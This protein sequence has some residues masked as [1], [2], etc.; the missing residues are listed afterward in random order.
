MKI[1]WKDQD[2]KIVI[3]V[4]EAQ[5]AMAH[6]FKT[7]NT[8]AVIRINPERFAIHKNT[9]PREEVI[10]RLTKYYE[11]KTI[12][13]GYCMISPTTPIY[14]TVEIANAKIEIRGSKN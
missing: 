5:K 1:K 6:I 10:R 11:D 9:F 12:Y 7:D 14:T 3:T 2:G 4:K 13:A 8:D